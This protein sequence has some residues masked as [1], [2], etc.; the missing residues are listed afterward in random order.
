MIALDFGGW[1]THSNQLNR[2]DNVAEELG[3]GLAAFWEDLGPQRANTV[4][5]AM[6]EFGRTGG[7]NGN[8]GTDHGW[9]TAMV[10]LGDLAGGRVLSRED[11]AAPGTGMST[12][13]GHWPGLGP[14][15]LHVQPGTNEER[16]LK[17]TTDYRDVIGE[18]LERFCG[19]PAAAVRD[20]VL[21]GYTPDH[22]GLFGTS[23]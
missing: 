21:R 19:L 20:Q 4:L 23:A 6:T 5:L 22:P 7:V 10:A 16:D 13:S 3:A 11:P 15:E 2:V 12:P 1:D 18:V 14:G 9:A 8:G 17:A